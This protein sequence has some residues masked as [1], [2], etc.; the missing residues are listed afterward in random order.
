MYTEMMAEAMKARAGEKYQPSNGTEGHLFMCEYC[1][2]CARDHFDHETGEGG[3]EI[4]S[5]TMLFNKDDKEYPS[6][7][8]IGSDGQPTCTAFEREEQSCKS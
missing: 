8:I 2:C 7:W 6:E 3:C 1:E 5:L 4:L